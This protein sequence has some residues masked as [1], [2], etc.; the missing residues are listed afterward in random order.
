MLHILY[1]K[2]STNKKNGMIMK[3]SVTLNVKI[4]FAF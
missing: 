4:A 3:Y 2:A 1:K